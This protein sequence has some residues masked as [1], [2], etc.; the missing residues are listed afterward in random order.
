MSMKVEDILKGIP[1]R[2]LQKLAHLDRRLHVE[3]SSTTR[4]H[5]HYTLHLEMEDMLAPSCQDKGI[6]IL[7]PSETTVQTE[8]HHLRLYDFEPPAELA[9]F[10]SP[11]V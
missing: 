1:K 6:P 8:M 2:M 10:V 4:G 5:S 7:A 9:L 3:V 11:V